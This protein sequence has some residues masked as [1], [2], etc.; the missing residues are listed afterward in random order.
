MCY[1]IIVCYENLPGW[2]LVR[3]LGA[4]RPGCAGPGWSAGCSHEGHAAG[5]HRLWDAGNVERRPVK[6]KIN[7]CYVFLNLPEF[8]RRH[9]FINDTKQNKL[10]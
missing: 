4:Q 10:Y 2:H 5:S 8:T 7:T 9:V 1:K 3:Y 6:Q